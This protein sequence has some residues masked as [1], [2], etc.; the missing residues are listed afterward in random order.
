M[1]AVVLCAAAFALAACGGEPQPKEKQAPAPAAAQPEAHRLSCE[2]FA[3][4]TP[5]L[6][7]QRFGAENVSEQILPGPE[8][9][10]YE[11]SVVFADDP[12]RRFEV[13]WNNTRTAPAAISIKGEA[14][15][16]EG[17]GRLEMGLPIAEV[18]RINGR[19]FKLW[20]FGWDYGGWASD[21]NG[22]AFDVQ[23]NCRVRVQ[24][25]A[26]SETAGAMGDSEFT[27]DNAAVRA[28]TPVVTEFGLSFSAP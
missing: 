18:E 28:A 23:Q 13:I 10:N 14:S 24:F 20:G 16:W 7:N 3:N 5:E 27:S 21:W 11:A 1:R 19:P 26:A 22:G 15:A 17:P 9:E 8:G 2:D 12:A 4:L 6:L 25:D